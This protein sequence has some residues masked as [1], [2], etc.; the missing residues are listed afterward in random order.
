MKIKMKNKYRITSERLNFREIT[1]EDF[2]SVYN[3]LK[4]K[5]IM[6]AWGH[7]FSEDETQEWIK[8]N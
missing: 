4:D 6:Y 8:K 5:E 1:E 3:I 7:G 2:H